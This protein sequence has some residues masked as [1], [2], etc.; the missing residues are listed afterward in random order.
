MKPKIYIVKNG[1]GAARL[2]RAGNRIQA[3]RHVAADTISAEIAGQEQLIAAIQKGIA[4]EDAGQE[5]E[6][7]TQDSE[8]AGLTD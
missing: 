4:V 3:I 5:S 1:S 8:S 2:V 6:P 7:E